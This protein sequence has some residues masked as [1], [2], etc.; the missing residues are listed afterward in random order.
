MS[1]AFKL[2]SHGC[3]MS[4]SEAT[5]HLEVNPN[6]AQS[7][8]LG[9]R[10]CPPGVLRDLGTL[11]AKIEKAALKELKRIDAAAGEV[12]LTV[13]D[14]DKAAQANGWPFASVQEAVYRRVLESLPLAQLERVKIV[15]E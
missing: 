15:K 14:S 4:L 11:F 7:W 12:T 5:A 10:S 9:R 13:P 2:L 8:W 3:G 6:N 1:S